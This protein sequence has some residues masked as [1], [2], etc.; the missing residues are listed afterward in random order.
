MAPI[1]T[2]M[3]LQKEKRGANIGEGDYTPSLVTND[4]W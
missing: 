1:K 3:K 2:V 4:A